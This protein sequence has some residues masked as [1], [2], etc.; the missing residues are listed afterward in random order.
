MPD[1]FSDIHDALGIK[2]VDPLASE[3]V[4]LQGSR[5]ISNMLLSGLG[6]L[7]GVTDALKAWRGEMTE[8]EQKMFALSALPGLLPGLKG[9]KA[10]GEAAVTMGKL[11]PEATWLGPSSLL[12]PQEYVDKLGG[13]KSFAE[14]F[15]ESFKKLSPYLSQ[16]NSDISDMAISKA[17]SKNPGASIMDIAKTNVAGP[18]S[19]WQA[20]AKAATAYAK[21]NA[22]RPSD[23]QRELNFPIPTRAS[24]LGFNTPAVHGTPDRWGWEGPKDQLKLPDEQLGVHFGNPRQA[25]HFTLGMDIPDYLGSTATYKAAEPRT[26]PALLQVQNPLETRD[27]GSW[28]VDEIKSALQEIN[29]GKH[30]NYIGGQRQVSPAQ[31]GQFPEAELSKLQNIRDVRDYLE[32][33]GFDSVKYTNSVEDPGHTSYILFAESPTNKGY[34]MGARSPFA[35]FDPSKLHLPSLAATGAGVL[36]YPLDRSGREQQ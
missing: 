8:D 33:K 2:P 29:E 13:A 16:D 10:A 27:L 25:A 23:F 34:V 6:S 31:K 18:S 36:A 17:L 15:P 1:D 3:P 28:G 35:Q 30:I 32:E 12:H 20:K 5:K 7:T 22:L 26:Y 4:G 19:D 14:N 21:S 9:A 24:E 11:F